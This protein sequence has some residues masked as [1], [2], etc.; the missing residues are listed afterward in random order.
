MRNAPFLY[1]GEIHRI[2]RYRRVAKRD[3]DTG[4]YYCSVGVLGCICEHVYKVNSTRFGPFWPMIFKVLL[5]ESWM[6][7]SYGLG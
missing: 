3:R 5:N 6:Y 1:Q 2:D 7:Q 4:K